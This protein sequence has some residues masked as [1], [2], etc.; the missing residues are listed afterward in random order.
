MWSQFGEKLGMKWKGK[1][2]EMV[3]RTNKMDVRKNLNAAEKKK[4]G[5]GVYMI[6]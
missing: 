2:D 3:F 4:H 1:V 6:N 5:K